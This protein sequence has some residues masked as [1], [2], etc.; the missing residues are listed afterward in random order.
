[1]RKRPSGSG[2]KNDNRV[3]G[4]LLAIME[5]HIAKIMTYQDTAK[6]IWDKADMM[7]G[8]KKNHSHVYR[9]Q[10]ELQQIRQQPNRSISKI[11]SLLQE[12]TD[13]LKL[14]QPPTSDIGEVHKREE[15]LLLLEL[16]FTR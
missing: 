10:Q 11:F 5:P 13:E 14:Y 7:Y 6:Q 12:K 3:V 16:P 15:I 1:M 4:W 9:L 2:E 8:K